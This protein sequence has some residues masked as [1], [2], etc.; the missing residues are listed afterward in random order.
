MNAEHYSAMAMILS[1]IAVFLMSTVLNMRAWYGRYNIEVPATLFKMNATLAWI[2]QES[3]VLVWCVYSYVHA[4]PACR[5]SPAN[6]VLL[7]FLA[8]HYF[9]RTCIYPLL[10]RGGKKTPVEVML[11]A[12]G[13]CVWNGYNQTTWLMQSH[14]YGAEWVNDF[15]FVGGLILAATGMAINVHSDHILRNLRKPGETGYR[16]PQG[17]MFELVSGANFLGEIIEWTGFAIAQW[18]LVGFAF[19]FFTASFIGPRG[20][21]HHQYYLRKFDNYPK[22]RRLLRR[23]YETM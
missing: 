18:S 22:H 12:F 8:A 19:A 5:G 15:R 1:G 21:H 2:L 7:F 20:Y 16:V 6:V 9:N 11:L 23:E 10:I 17:G 3:P 14:V 13:F 4:N